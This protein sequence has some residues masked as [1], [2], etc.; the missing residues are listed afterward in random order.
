[1]TLSDE[2]AFGVLIGYHA[3]EDDEYS[4]EPE[5]FAARFTAFRNAVRDCVESFPLA[6]SAVAREFGHATYLEFADGDQL[7][8]PITWI[9]TVRAKLNARDLKSVGVLS[10]GGR[11]LHEP[12]E[13]A[14]A[15]ACGVDYLPVSLPS[16]PLRRAL[17]A[18]TATHGADEND[19][20]A[21]GP[22]IYVDT[23]AV[24]ALGRTLKNA[25][26]PLAVAGA[27]FYRV[28]R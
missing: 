25:P 28:A 17:Y 10:H 11:W 27:T 7:E 9:K 22:G 1:M 15:S 18:E 3:L 2:N 26:T 14:P 21:W 24:E 8:D 23:E 6:S 5:Q 4:L 20:A 13:A 19:E 16:E 12:A